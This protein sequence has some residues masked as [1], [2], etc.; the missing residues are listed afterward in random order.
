MPETSSPRTCTASPAGPRTSLLEAPREE[1]AAPRAPRAALADRRPGGRGG[2]RPLRRAQ[3]LLVRRVPLARAH[4]EEAARADDPRHSTSCSSGTSRAGPRR[5]E[6]AAC[7]ATRGCR[8]GTRFDGKLGC[9]YHGWVYD[10]GGNVVEVPSLGPSQRGEV[11]DERGHAQ[12]GLTVEPCKLGRVQ[13]FE[14]REQD[15]LIYVFM[16]GD[17]SSAR[18]EPFRVPYW[19]HP[20]WTV[21]L[22]GDA[23]PERGDEPR[24]ELHGRAAHGVRALGVVP[25]PRAQARAAPR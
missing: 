25:Q 10:A 20:D 13:R 18:A 8:R 2:S 22:H 4:G 23:L 1:P 7:T 21:L 9:P 14:T 17:A 3:G 15:G 24:R 16:G 19:G 5:C 6:T 11:L 12:S